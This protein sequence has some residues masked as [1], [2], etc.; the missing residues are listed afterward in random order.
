MHVHHLSTIHIG[1]SIQ[2]A[3]QPCQPYPHDLFDHCTLQFTTIT[4]RT[5]QMLSTYSLRPHQDRP[6]H[7]K[8]NPT[9]IVS[10]I[11]DPPYT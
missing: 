8:L 4:H 5:S 2:K 6:Q 1:M 7:I 10:S 3:R 11:H 9:S